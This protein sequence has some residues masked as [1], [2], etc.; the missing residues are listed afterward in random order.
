MGLPTHIRNDEDQKS[1]DAK[2]MEKLAAYPQLDLMV[3]DQLQIILSQCSLIEDILS[4][5][6]GISWSA[7]LEYEGDLC[8]NMQTYL[9][10][11]SAQLGFKTGSIHRQLRRTSGSVNRELLKQILQSLGLKENDDKGIPQG[12]SAGQ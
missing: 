3:I 9:N 2:L 1:Y 8:K 6:T 12:I 5:S 10:P 4:Q 7:Q 11:I